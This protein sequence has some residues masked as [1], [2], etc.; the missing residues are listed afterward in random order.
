MI[1]GMMNNLHA[2]NILLYFHSVELMA[3][4]N[5]QEGGIRLS[6][7]MNANVTGYT[8]NMVQALLR[9]YC[10]SLIP[11]SVDLCVQFLMREYKI[12]SAPNDQERGVRLSYVYGKRPP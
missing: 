6:L 8:N 1:S 4:F 3:G 11:L 7:M 5:G 9:D 10:K 12:I 2:E